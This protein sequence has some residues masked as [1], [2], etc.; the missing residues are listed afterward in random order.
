MREFAEVLK[1]RSPRFTDRAVDFGI[2]EL[3][4]DLATDE[5]P[6]GR[7]GVAIAKQIKKRQ[8]ASLNERSNDWDPAILLGDDLPDLRFETDVV[9]RLIHD[10]VYDGSIRPT[11]LDSCVSRPHVSFESVIVDLLISCDD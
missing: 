8:V 7:K 2:E 5:F 6:S 10:Q 9:R 1:R 4:K 11:G 3:T